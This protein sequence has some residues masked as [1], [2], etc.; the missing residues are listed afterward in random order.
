MRTIT[1]QFARKMADLHWSLSREGYD[2]SAHHVTRWEHWST[3]AIRIERAALD[4]GARCH[5]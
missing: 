3:L 5:D 4:A 1:A 2:G